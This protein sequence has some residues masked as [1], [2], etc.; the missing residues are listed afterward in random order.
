MKMANYNAIK[1]KISKYVERINLLKYPGY[2]KDLAY[3]KGL[4]D[5]YRRT[6]S[7]KAEELI[8]NDL[9][10]KLCIPKN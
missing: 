10:E 2:E 6:M 8:L 9:R 3:L 7:P 1:E 4:C 5:Y